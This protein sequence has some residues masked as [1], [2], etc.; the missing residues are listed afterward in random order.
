MVEHILNQDYDC[1]GLDL[2]GYDVDDNFLDDND[3]DFCGIGK[4]KWRNI[5]SSHDPWSRWEHVKRIMHLCDCNCLDLDCYD[6]DNN[7]LNLGD[8][9][10][11]V[12]KA[13][14]RNFIPISP[15]P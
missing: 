10:C 1:D 14:W 3:D 8:N 4:A 15:S 12:V 7:F 13:K 9:F 11:G 5:S 2:D 6:V